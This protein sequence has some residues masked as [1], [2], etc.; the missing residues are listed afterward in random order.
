MSPRDPQSE[1]VQITLHRMSSPLNPSD[2]FSIGEDCNS[3][4]ATSVLFLNV[5]ALCVTGALGGSSGGASDAG[6]TAG[7]VVGVLL[8]VA[9]AL[10]A[11]LFLLWRR[12]Q[13][14]SKEVVSPSSKGGE[15]GRAIRSAVVMVTIST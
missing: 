10:A 6:T 15:P 12:R 7:I 4:P 13:K 11:G 1:I 14:G 8:A 2:S 3:P 9:L 5:F